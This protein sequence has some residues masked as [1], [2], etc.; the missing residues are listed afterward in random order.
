ML[1]KVDKQFEKYRNFLPVYMYMYIN[2]L[3]VSFQDN[4]PEGA[5]S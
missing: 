3:V 1:L 2:L 4:L 5:I